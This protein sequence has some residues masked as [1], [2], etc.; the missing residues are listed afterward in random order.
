MCWWKSSVVNWKEA[1]RKCKLYLKHI[2]VISSVGYLSGLLAQRDNTN[3]VNCFFSSRLSFNSTGGRAFLQVSKL[4][5][6]ILWKISVN[7]IYRR[8]T[9]AIFPL[10][11]R[12]KGSPNKKGPLMS[13]NTLLEQNNDVTQ[14]YYQ[15]LQS[16]FSCLLHLA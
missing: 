3:F 2:F 14:L 15:T 4:C 9:V 6:T 10:C 7:V 5:V 8:S 1:K 12:Q 11:E 13:L 16:N